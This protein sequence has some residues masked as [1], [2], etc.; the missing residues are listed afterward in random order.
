MT[1]RRAL[2]T[3]LPSVAGVY[4]VVAH[5]IAARFQEARDTA[6]LEL[7]L[8]S[9]ALLNFKQGIVFG[10][11]YRQGWSLAG[12]L[13]TQEAFTWVTLTISILTFVSFV[14]GVRWFRVAVSYY[15]GGVAMAAWALIHVANPSSPVLPMFEFF[16]LCR[17]YI[18][19]R[20]AKVSEARSADS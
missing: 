16:V 11:G 13:F 20:H 3:P 9:F 18:I 1:I 14:L 4:R 6:V 7:A 17:I 12:R 19:G 5:R 15:A 10:D 8:A 2:A